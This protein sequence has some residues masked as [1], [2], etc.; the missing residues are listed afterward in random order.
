V[1]KETMKKVQFCTLEPGQTFYYDLQTYIKMRPRT[2]EEINAL[3]TN[4][5][6]T[7]WFGGDIEVEVDE[8]AVQKTV[9]I[10]VAVAV[11]SEGKWN[12]S[13]WNRNNGKNNDIEAMDLAIS[14]VDQGECRFF[15]EATLPIPE[16][17]TIDADVIST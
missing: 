1:K 3:N 8:P 15:I 10:R 14:G 16:V 6:M 2:N 4:R 9:K 12:A 7:E 11:D 5:W 17:T 13:G